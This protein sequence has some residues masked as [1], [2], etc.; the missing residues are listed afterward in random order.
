MEKLIQIIGIAWVVMC[1][2]LIAWTFIEYLF[3]KF[4]D[5]KI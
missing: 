5:P 1:V 4:K 2:G 3:L